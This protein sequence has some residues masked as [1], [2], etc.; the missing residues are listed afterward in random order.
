MRGNNNIGERHLAI[1]GVSG[2]S[3]IKIGSVSG[4]R[5]MIMSHA[6]RLSWVAS[7]IRLVVG[8]ITR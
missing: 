3:F 8:S 6:W 4:F 7:P 5:V 1:H 2:R